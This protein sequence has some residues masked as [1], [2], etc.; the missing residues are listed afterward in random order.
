MGILPINEFEMHEKQEQDNH[1]SCTGCEGAALCG[2]YHVQAN[3][4]K[5]FREG[6]R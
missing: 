2:G 4:S 3:P 5:S 1:T 6:T